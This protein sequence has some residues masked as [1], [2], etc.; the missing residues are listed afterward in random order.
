MLIRNWMNASTMVILYSSVDDEDD[1][2][3]ESAHEIP[4]HQC[5]ARKGQMVPYDGRTCSNEKPHEAIKVMGQEDN[6]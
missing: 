3:G 1:D 6:H 2:D 4:V 5:A